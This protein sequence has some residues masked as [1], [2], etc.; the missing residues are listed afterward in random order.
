MAAKNENRCWPGYEPVPGKKPN[1]EG[2]CKPKP[3]SK[4]SPSEKG[5]RAKRRKQLDEWEAAHPGSR[6]QAAQHLR[7]PGAKKAASK[8]TGPPSKKK[9]SAKQA[10]SKKPRP[11]TRRRQPAPEKGLLD[12]KGRPS[13]SRRIPIGRRSIIHPASERVVPQALRT[14]PAERTS[15]YRLDL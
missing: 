5:F 2:S 6:P 12:E 13:V 9:A 7:A 3:E 10:T 8:R 11:N 4:S 1:S 14:G 15:A